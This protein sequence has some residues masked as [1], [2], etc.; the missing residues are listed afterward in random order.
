MNDGGKGSKPRPFSISQEE[1]SN[2]WNAIF[3]RDLPDELSKV[4][5]EANSS[6]AESESSD[7]KGN[8]SE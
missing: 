3:A 5:P 2:R 4:L 1:W 7:D 8:D 6:I